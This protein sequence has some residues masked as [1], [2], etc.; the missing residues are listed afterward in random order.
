MGELTVNF[1]DVKSRAAVPAGDYQGVISDCVLRQKAGAE[2][3]YLNWDVVIAEGEYEGRHVF[4]TSSFNPKALFNMMN[5]FRNLGYQEQEYN[6]QFNDD[7]G[8]VTE[9]E[10]VGLACMARVFN[11]LYQG[12]QTSKI[13]DILGPNGENAA[14]APAE[15]EAPAAPAARPATKAAAAPKAAS[16]GPAPAAGAA[17]R[18]PFPAPA[19]AGAAKRTF[20]K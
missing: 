18:S 19:A 13:S 3:A 7:T 11:E 8:Q 6:V 20:A 14:D 9:P 1:A 2:H 12:R 15:E 10:V 16:N 4:M 5:A 17:R